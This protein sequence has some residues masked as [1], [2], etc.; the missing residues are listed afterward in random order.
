MKT[1]NTNPAID[2][3]AYMDQLFREVVNRYQE[4]VIAKVLCERETVPASLND[5]AFRLAW[6][7]WNARQ[8]G[9]EP[10]KES[11]TT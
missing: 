5:R 3:D 10:T 4:V 1:I 6:E 11:P 2:K 9:E 8:E 7:K